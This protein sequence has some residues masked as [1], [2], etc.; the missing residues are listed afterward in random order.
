MWG[1]IARDFRWIHTMVRRRID[2]LID[3]ETPRHLVA[4]AIRHSA[5]VAPEPRPDT[6]SSLQ[7]DCRRCKH[8][9]VSWDPAAPYLC[10]GFGFKSRNLPSWEV[11][12]ADGAPCRLFGAR[13]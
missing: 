7:P 12:Q 13:L 10:R 2:V 3:D 1:A 4:P 5:V 11:Q 6:V 9:A 8:F